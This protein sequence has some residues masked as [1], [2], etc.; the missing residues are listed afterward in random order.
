V[1]GASRPEVPDLAP[2]AVDLASYDD[3]LEEV[4]A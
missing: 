3:L 2:Q 4:V 1:S